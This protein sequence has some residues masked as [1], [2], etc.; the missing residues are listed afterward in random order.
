MMTKQE[1]YS[2]PYFDRL[3]ISKLDEPDFDTGVKHLYA[4]QIDRTHYLLSQLIV[5][6]GRYVCYEYLLVT[7]HGY[8]DKYHYHY[9][10]YRPLVKV[11]FE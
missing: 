6:Y 11:W 5:A 2:I 3:R 10:S 8:I 9:K 7:I 4:R 1:Y